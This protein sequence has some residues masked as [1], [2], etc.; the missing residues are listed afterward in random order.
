MQPHFVT[1]IFWTVSIFQ[2]LPSLMKNVAWAYSI[3]TQHLLYWSGDSSAASLL[4][5]EVARR[6]NMVACNG[7]SGT[8]RSQLPPHTS[9][10]MLGGKSITIFFGIILSLS[11]S[12]LTITVCLLQEV[13]SSFTLALFWTTASLF[14]TTCLFIICLMPLTIGLFS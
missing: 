13:F 5:E 11:H 8:V 4:L 6:W 1:V 14:V 2:L 7:P 10:W 3:G 12:L 9:T